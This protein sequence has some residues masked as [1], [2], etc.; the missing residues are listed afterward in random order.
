MCVVLSSMR[1]ES[2]TMTHIRC[3]IADTCLAIECNADTNGAG[4]PNRT[5]DVP[6]KQSCA[7]SHTNSTER[8]RILSG[9]MVIFDSKVEFSL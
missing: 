5:Q 9:T 3:T 2:I 4:V 8:E 1:L 6:K 7:F